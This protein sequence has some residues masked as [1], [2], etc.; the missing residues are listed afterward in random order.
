MRNG[1]LYHLKACPKRSVGSRRGTKP[2]ELEGQEGEASLGEMEVLEDFGERNDPI[3]R[4][5]HE[6]TSSH[7]GRGLRGRVDADTEVNM[8][9]GQMVV[10]GSGW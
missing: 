9:R 2:A 7:D 5:C 6:S 10:V 4:F 1:I 3:W 8:I